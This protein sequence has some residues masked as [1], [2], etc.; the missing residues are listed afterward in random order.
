ML[1]KDFLDK[2]KIPYV[3]FN[4]I[5]EEKEGHTLKKPKNIPNGWPKWNYEKC[6]DYNKSNS[7]TTNAMNINVAKSKYMIIDIDCSEKKEEYLK[8]YG[9]Q[10][11]SKSCRRKLPHLWRLKHIEDKNINKVDTINHIDLVYNNI[12]ELKDSMIE[13]INEGIPIFDK[14]P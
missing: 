1:V 6:M 9:N 3:F 2:E 10:W 14:Y 8:E 11:M 7:K 13:N 5:L 12:F 4:M